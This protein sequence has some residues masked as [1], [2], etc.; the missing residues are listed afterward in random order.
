MSQISDGKFDIN[1]AIPMKYSNLQKFVAHFHRGVLIHIECTKLMDQT[2]PVEFHFHL[3][4]TFGCSDIHQVKHK[5]AHFFSCISGAMTFTRLN[6]NLGVTF[7]AFSHLIQT[8]FYLKELLVQ[9]VDVYLC[10]YL[11]RF[12]GL[13]LPGY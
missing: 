9:P 5:S 4:C 1:Q 11:F 10:G 8:Y 2:T 7:S 6:T 13:S 3:D 12:Q